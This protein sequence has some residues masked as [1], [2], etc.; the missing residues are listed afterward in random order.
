MMKHAAVAFWLARYAR[1][2]A[3]ARDLDAGAL[4]ALAARRLRAL[5]ADAQR[6]PFHASR[7]R[8]AGLASLGALR[9]VDL[10][11]A[12]QS[13]PPV[14][15]RDLRDAGDGAL[16]DGRVHAT[17]LSSQSSGSSGEPFR[18]YYD[19]RAWAMLKYL[20]KMRARRAAGVTLSDRI[21]ILDAIP[22]SAEGES[23]LERAGRLRRVSV[24]R[25]P[26]QLATMLAD[27]RP[28]SIYAL[29]SALLEI[30][31][32]IDAGA[33]HVRTHRIFTSGEILAGGARQAIKAA[34]GGEL[35]DIYGTSETKE[36][37]WECADGSRHINADVVHVE[38]LDERG[39]VVPIG[40]E[41][42]IVVT[43]LM[44]RAMP[45]VRYRTGDRG[46]LVGER[47]SCGR[48]A[49]LLGVV[50]GREADTLEL[51]DGT[52]RSPYRLTMALERIP[53]LAQY[54]ILQTERDLLRVIAVATSARTDATAL[55]RAIRDALRDELPRNIRIEVSIVERIERG[56][57]EKVRVVHPLPRTRDVQGEL[58]AH[59]ATQ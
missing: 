51:P 48:G 16:R 56:P 24:F 6:S 42:E 35:F 46:A 11:L 49:P 19:A 37:A 36:I 10:P 57:R 25:P 54:Q 21:A 53:G 30:A 18:V 38:I 41:G 23:L 1:T 26:A 13:L 40:T 29:P 15:K 12:L 55:E 47:C 50:S 44:N 52:T 22:I 17:W 31:R 58:V 3:R 34:Y 5:L 9:D 4:G 28:A 45:L 43:L 33:P 20:V 27:Y 7:M 14:T 39:A 2:A 8:D 32:A 59:G